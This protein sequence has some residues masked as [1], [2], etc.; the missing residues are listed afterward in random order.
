MQTNSTAMYWK[1]L[2]NNRVKCELCPHECILK[3]NDV[4]KCRARINKGGI[5][6]TLT[7]GKV[8]SYAYDPIEKKP[9]AHFH[10]GASIFSIGTSGCNLACTFCQN[11]NLVSY[12]GQVPL[13]SPKE[14]IALAAQN[15]S[16]GIAYTYNEPTIWYEFMLE[17]CKLAK[18][19]GLINVMVTNGYINPE[20]MK[21]LLPWLDAMN[22]DLK[23]STDTFYKEI[24]SGTLQP[25]M[26][27]IALCHSKVHVEVTML[28][29]DTL[30][31]DWDAFEAKCQWLSQINPE[32]P[33]HISRY[34]PAHKLTIPKTRLETLSKAREIALKYLKNVH[35]GNAFI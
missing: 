35:I 22:I 12:T 7:Y 16:I 23:G 13:T 27:T 1:S 25:V 17:T 30:N 15:G 14:I 20:P 10:P 8:I 33:L 29:I 28:L 34:F 11:H 6:H 3:N 26:D 5:L 19:A 9:L 31:T 32:L 2:D 4:G 21:A 18:S 24:C